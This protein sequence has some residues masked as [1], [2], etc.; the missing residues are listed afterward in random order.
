MS[1]DKIRAAAEQALAALDRLPADLGRGSLNGFVAQAAY[2]LRTALAEQ[3]PPEPSDLAHE[4]WALAQCAPGEGIEDAVARIDA[5][6]TQPEATPMEATR[7]GTM[8]PT[9]R[10]DAYYY[11]FEPTGVLAIDLILSAVACAGKCFH[12]TSEWGD[13]VREPYHERLRGESPL[14]W[15]QN[16]AND[17]AAAMRLAPPA[18]KPLEH[19]GPGG[20]I[21]WPHDSEGTPT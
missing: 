17:A 12:S 21:R 20:T 7:F 4:L 8:E 19:D 16:A 2:A 1:N 14:D 11:S 13:T 10:M 6:L 18:K 5:R 3:P 9:F 15:I